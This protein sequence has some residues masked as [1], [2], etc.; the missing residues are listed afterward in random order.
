MQRHLQ[1]HRF[2]IKRRES[3]VKLKT[4]KKGLFLFGVLILVIGTQLFSFG[5]NTAITPLLVSIGGYEYYALVA[6]LGSAGTL[7]SLPACGAICNK[8]GLRSGMLLGGLLMLFGRGMLQVESSNVFLLM[9]WQVVGSVGSGLLMSTPYVLIAT[10][11]ERLE[12]MKCYGYIASATGFGALVGPVLAGMLTDAG[13][14][15]PAFIIWVPLYVVGFIILYMTYPNIKQESMKFDVKGLALLTVVISCF[16]LWTGL[17]GNAFP[18]LSAG[19]L[20]PAAA[21]AAAVLLVKHSSKIDNPTVPFYIFKNKRF[22]TAF[23]INVTQVVIPTCLTG[24]VLV[25]ILY[26][27]N[28]NATIGSTCTIPYTLVST[29]LGF[30]VGSF[31]AK[32]FTRNLRLLGLTAAVCGVICVALL[33]LLQPTS[34]MMMIWISSSFGGVTV[35]IVQSIMTPFFQFGMAQEDYGAA[36]GMFTF[37]ATGGA[38]VFVSIVGVIVNATG[39]IKWVFYGAMAVI[40]I[41]LLLVL[42]KLKIAEEEG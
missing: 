38:T 32:N 34:S 20:M 27:M 11:Y 30:F 15:R 10:V 29:I 12:A 22:R 3:M 17:S 21:V 41:M 33:C 40:L 8:L 2:R 42:A 1:P 5:G 19:L 9:V 26:T 37:S 14:A 16:V 7:I 13:L 24:Y 35:A 36:Q 28:Q 4:Q 6:A 31:L 39:N 23:F 18:W 25:Y